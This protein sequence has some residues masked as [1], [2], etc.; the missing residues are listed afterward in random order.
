MSL[1][2]LREILGDKAPRTDAELRVLRDDLERLARA[3]VEGVVEE[4]KA[5]S[6]GK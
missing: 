3:V 5:V 2:R 6:G 4:R 1:G